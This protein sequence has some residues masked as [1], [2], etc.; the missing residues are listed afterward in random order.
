MSEPITSK[1]G[2]LKRFLALLAVISLLLSHNPSR[3]AAQESKLTLAVAGD[4]MLARTV[5]KRIQEAGWHAPFVSIPEMI[6]KADIAFANLE[7]P[8]SFR[9]KPYPGKP[10]EV[11]F[12]ANPGSLLG[13]KAAGFDVLSLA[14]NHSNDYGPLAL[15]DTIAGLQQLGIH[16][17]GAGKSAQEARQPAI[18]ERNGIRL[19]FLAYAEPIWSVVEAKDGPPT[20][21]GVAVLREADIIAD[22]QTAAKQAD[23]VLV[24]LHWGEEFHKIPRA[25]DR[26]LA[27]RLIDAGALAVLGH[28]PHVLQ[29]AEW[30]RQ[31][32]ILYSMGNFVFDMQSD[33]TYDSAIALINIKRIGNG[34]V[35]YKPGATSLVVEKLAFQPVKLKRG[36][37]GPE[38]IDKTEER[39]LQNLLIERLELVGS[40]WKLSDSGLIEV[41][42]P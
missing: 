10:E 30:Y 22:I 12:R 5:D 9:G 19:A 36:T 39:R 15:M 35:P 1:A 42:R 41:L 38:P 29:G 34:M 23:G 20:Q 8:A 27:K 17:C 28:H 21:T 25:A 2:A 31:G 3:L 37:W 16:T 33:A 14:N 7:S 26:E 24:S 13:L 40:P 6:Q 11:T 4:I 18:L 32:I